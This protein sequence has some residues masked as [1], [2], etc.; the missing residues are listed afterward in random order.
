VPD[1]AGI[2]NPSADTLIDV[3]VFKAERLV[4]LSQHNYQ[5]EPNV[6]FSPDMK[7]IIFR[8]NLHGAMHVYAVELA[9]AK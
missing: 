7:W 4:N 3:G 5:L 1:V 9:K 6:H 2:K 8:S